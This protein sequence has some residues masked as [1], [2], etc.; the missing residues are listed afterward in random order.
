MVAMR[1]GT[2]KLAEQET[3]SGAEPTETVLWS[4][5]DRTVSFSAQDV[6]LSQS[7]DS[8]KYLRVV[9]AYT[10]TSSESSFREVIIPVW[11]SEKTAYMY[12]YVSSSNT[13]YRAALCLKNSSNVTRA[14]TFWILEGGEK[15]HFFACSNV[16]SSGTSNTGCIPVYIYGIK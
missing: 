13:G 8:F 7:V 2:N 10:T 3:A 1:F 11:N 6:T 14:R 4:N 5:S 9:Y 16:G 12:Q 15:V